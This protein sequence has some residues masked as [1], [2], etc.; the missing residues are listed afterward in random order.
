VSSAASDALMV[1]FHTVN[2]MTCLGEHEFVNTIVTRTTFEAMG[3]VR[4]IA[5]HDGFVE[6]G[7]VTEA[8]T[9]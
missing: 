3:V 5:S 4:V 9:V 2:T 7:L 8:A 6:N 1:T